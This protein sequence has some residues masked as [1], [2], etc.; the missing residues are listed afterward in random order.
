MKANNLS[1]SF[2]KT[3]FIIFHSSSKKIDD[4][5]KFK[6]DGKHLPPTTSRKHPAWGVKPPTPHLFQ[7]LRQTVKK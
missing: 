3:E 2:T 5:L 7:H 6:L 1:L 4:S